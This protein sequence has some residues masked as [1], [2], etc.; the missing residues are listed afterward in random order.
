MHPTLS[1]SSDLPLARYRVR[2]SDRGD[3]RLV[4]RSAP[5]AGPQSFQS[6]RQ[7]H[8]HARCTKFIYGRTTNDAQIAVGEA[9][10]ASL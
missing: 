9:G 10:L 7:P 1:P 2:I 8:V 4:H 5:F 3:K 6:Q